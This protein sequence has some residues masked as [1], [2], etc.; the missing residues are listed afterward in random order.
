MSH[1]PE[2]L[3]NWIQPQQILVDVDAQDVEQALTIAA[4]AISSAHVIDAAPIFRALWRRE[5]IGSTAIGHNLAIPH[6]RSDAIASPLTVFMRTRSPVQV[7][8]GEPISQ[9][10]VILVPK[11]G[12]QEDHLQLLALAATLFEGRESR[13]QISRA[14]DAAEIAKAFQNA[15]KRVARNAASQRVRPAFFTR[16]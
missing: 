4:A 2:R 16:S 6:A 14:A 1:D 7:S 9:F 12:R 3:A 8:D 10:L 13:D 5:Q 15:L 11:A